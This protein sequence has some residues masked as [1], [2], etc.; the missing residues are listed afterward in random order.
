MG[1]EGKKVKQYLENDP[2]SSRDT[3][4]PKGYVDLVSPINVSCMS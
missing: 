3:D 2:G 1:L 4:I